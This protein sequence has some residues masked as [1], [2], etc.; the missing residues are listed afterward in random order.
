[1][2]KTYELWDG[3][4]RNLIGAYDAEA[5]ALTFV[6]TYVA[7]HGSAYAQSWVLLWDD[8]TADEAGQIAE[9]PALLTL[10]ARADATPE[11]PPPKPAHQIRSGSLH[12]RGVIRA[13][14][15]RQRD[16]GRGVEG[17]VDRRHVV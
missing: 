2:S 12:H 1:M 15:L 10:A 9:G 8:D 14:A 17:V 16:L 4:S 11:A 3:G 7:Q 5:E 13:T 6:R